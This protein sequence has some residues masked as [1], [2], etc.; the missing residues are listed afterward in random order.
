[1]KIKFIGRTDSAFFIHGKIYDVESYEDGW[2]R[3]FDETD[4][5]YLY[6]TESFEVVEGSIVDVPHY[7]PPELKLIYQRKYNLSDDVT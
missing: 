7:Y 2:Y 1:M 6:P 4:E 5:D 3:I